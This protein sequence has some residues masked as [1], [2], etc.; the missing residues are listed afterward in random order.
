MFCFSS[1]RRHTRCAL[2]TGVQTWALPISGPWRAA[3]HRPRHGDLRRGGLDTVGGEQH[4]HRLGDVQGRGQSPPL[5][6]L[7]EP[8]GMVRASWRESV[9]QAVSISVVAGALTKRQYRNTEMI[10]PRRD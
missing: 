10:L 8:E 6:E 5:L 2:V 7:V 3:V 1:R 9:C 4:A